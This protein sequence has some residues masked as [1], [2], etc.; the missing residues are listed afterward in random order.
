MSV[1]GYFSCGNFADQTRNSFRTTTT[2][3]PTQAP[4]PPTIPTNSGWYFLV[5]LG[6][7]A[8][9]PWAAAPIFDQLTDPC[10]G[11]APD[12][13]VEVP[14]IG[15]DVVQQAT[16]HIGDLIPTIQPDTDYWVRWRLFNDTDDELDEDVCG[17]YRTP[18]IPANGAACLTGQVDGDSAT[19][20]IGW[21]EGAWN[22]LGSGLTPCITDD[23][24]VEWGEVGAG[25]P[26]TDTVPANGGTPSFDATGLQPGRFYEYRFSGTSQFGES[27][28]PS[29]TCQFGTPVPNVHNVECAP[30]GPSF[31]HDTQALFEG[32]ADG[33]PADHTIRI[34][35]SS[36]ADG[37]FDVADSGVLANGDGS[38]GQ[39]VGNIFAGL[40]PTTTYWFVVEVRDAGGV[41]VS[42]SERCQLT[43]TA[44][45]GYFD[46]LACDGA[47]ITPY[48]R[49]DLV[50][51][52]GEVDDLS[53]ETTN[54]YRVEHSINGGPFQ[55]VPPQ[56]LEG[57]ASNPYPANLGSIVH[58]IQFPYDAGTDVTV[59]LTLVRD[60]DDTET[61]ECSGRTIEYP[62]P[63]CETLL[64]SSAQATGTTFPVRFGVSSGAEGYN[65]DYS[66]Q[67][68]GAL[69]DTL[70]VV[71]GTTP[72][73][74][75]PETV[76]EPAFGFQATTVELSGLE[77]L[78]TYYFRAQADEEH[79]TQGQWL[80][81]GECSFTTPKVD[82][83]CFVQ[84]AF[85]TR[86]Q[87]FAQSTEDPMQPD[88]EL[89]TFLATTP[90]GPY[91]LIGTGTPGLS[92]DETI[93]NDLLPATTYFVRVELW[94]LD[95]D[96]L[97]GWNDDECQFTT[98]ALTNTVS[99]S[100]ADVTQTSATLVADATGTLPATLALRIRY[101]G[102]EFIGPAGDEHFEHPATG[103]P[104][105]TPYS[106]IVDVVR[107]SDGAVVSH[108][109]SDCQFRTEPV[110][111][112]CDPATN[113]EETEASVHGSSPLLAND[114]RLRLGIS[115]NPAGPFPAFQ[116]GPG[117]QTTVD[118]D[119]DGLDPDTMYYYRVDVVQDGEVV[120]SS[121]ICSFRTFPF[122][123][124]TCSDATEVGR[125]F[126]TLNGSVV[127]ARDN[128]HRVRIVWGET[129]GGPYPNE[130]PW[131]VTDGTDPWPVSL[132]I[133]G[134]TPETRYYWIV[135]VEDLDDPF[136]FAST[137]CRVTT[138]PPKHS[139]SGGTPGA[140]NRPCEP[141]AE[142]DD[143]CCDDIY[144]DGALRDGISQEKVDEMIEVATYLVWAASGRRFGVC[145]TKV[146]PCRDDSCSGF[147]W[148]TY[149]QSFHPG[150][151]LPAYPVLTAD[152]WTNCG[153]P[154][155]DGCCDVNCEMRFPR[156]PVVEVTE[157][158]VDGEVFPDHKYRVDNFD[159]LVRTDGQC[160]PTCQSMDL[161]DTEEGTFSITYRY[162]RPVPPGG[163]MAVAALACELI[164]DCHRMECQ[165]PRRLRTISRQGVTAQFLDPM[166]F[167]DQG[168][169]GMTSVDL[170]IRAVNPNRLQRR[171]RVYRPDAPRPKHRR[172]D[173]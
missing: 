68:P 6:A 123:V 47:F 82:T 50:V 129:E 58:H 78:T 75:Y 8:T 67:E 108:P 152:G 94:D 20:Q 147:S 14:P 118:L 161:H 157:I 122:P 11:Q 92:V 85:P 135:E 169:F 12:N 2:F 99:C 74:P 144:K 95:G 137:E 173:T 59:R 44:E 109:A 139:G 33:V 164:K 89:R 127:G 88:W 146:R 93:A 49:N 131:T 110:T 55:V 136:E 83:S 62:T 134:L 114:L 111:V 63:T 41:P 38:T 48:S 160:W 1:N 70:R 90:G 106:F 166:E 121:D 30:G 126:A 42:R 60:G 148:P 124:P 51:A 46:E 167:F 170:W 77:P 86:A 13:R 105:D 9:G 140:D 24:I 10:A 117:G 21:F 84:G 155:C 171:S 18:A 66:A 5:E 40:S 36:T 154:C 141:W 65:L 27:W 52:W 130:G 35:V 28:G 15:A 29:A 163:K 138:L 150:G 107:V 145:E 39:A 4:W 159:M 31:I 54:E 81:I 57:E 22:F 23:V 133:T 113:I 132:D 91:T 61:I 172:I 142:L 97:I 72:G 98:L 158:K 17:P 3:R 80:D 96:R 115:T 19:M 153:S 120:A 165:L 64:R 143:L 16:A 112:T 156:G 7:S 53:I 87:I 100:V 116:P 25:F 45:P 43:T 168:L 125:E 79:Q 119:L 56:F 32:T 71:Y 151:F 69:P 162:G 76:E 73:G 26:N 37:P 34:L 102:Q 104:P 103:L 101:D 149:D 128:H